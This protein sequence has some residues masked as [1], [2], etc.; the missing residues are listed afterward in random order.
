MSTAPQLLH[1]GPSP[2]WLPPGSRADVM[3]GE[4]PTGEPTGLVRLLVVRDREVF[5]MPRDDGRTDIP[6]RALV[7]GDDPGE[8][9]RALA[10]EVL[11]PAVGLRPLGYVRNL[12]I[13]PEPSYP[14]PVPVA[15]FVVWTP[16]GPA[17]PQVPGSW[18]SEADLRE[19]HWWPLVAEVLGAA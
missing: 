3:L 6:T 18:C 12:V 4:P 15:C 17:E 14:W 7:A 10:L 8:G 16:T 11:G 2:A 13:A 9:V 19:R 5:C 1:A